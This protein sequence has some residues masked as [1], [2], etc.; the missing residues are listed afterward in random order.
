LYRGLLVQICSVFGYF[1]RKTIE[2]LVVEIAKNTSGFEN[3]PYRLVASNFVHTGL[4]FQ[5]N[6]DGYLNG[7]KK[8]YFE[9]LAAGLY[10]C[11]NSDQAVA[12]N[13]EMFT[14]YLGN[15]TSEQLKSRFAD[16]GLDDPVGD[17]VGANSE[18]R[19][20]FGGGGARSVSSSAKEALDALLERRNSIVHSSTISE[21][22][23]IDE[24]EQGIAFIRA[25]SG[26]IRQ[27]VQ[28]S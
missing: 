10:S 2:N 26:G 4:Y 20:Y 22:V 9:K 24:V 23:T 7:T 8:L 19:N 6:R 14:E 27:L 13:A 12:L 16:M 11:R 25:L 18:L 5:K 28:Q 17:R 1:C 15:C 21:T 3:L